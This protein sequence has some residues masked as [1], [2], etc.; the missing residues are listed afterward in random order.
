[1]DELNLNY[2]SPEWGRFRDW[3]L[4]EQ[5]EVYRHL[6]STSTTAEQTQQYRGKA[7]FINKLLDLGEQTP[8]A[9]R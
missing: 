2:A 6:A 3:L 8:A 7:A 1:M 5:Q 4:K 9:G